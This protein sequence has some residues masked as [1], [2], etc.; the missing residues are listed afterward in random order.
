MVQRKT[1]FSEGRKINSSLLF[2]IFKPFDITECRRTQQFTECLWISL[3]L[4]QQKRS[5]PYG[6]KVVSV[7][8]SYI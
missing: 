2:T 4:A 3:L 1:Y 6:R 5:F 7:H 8:Y